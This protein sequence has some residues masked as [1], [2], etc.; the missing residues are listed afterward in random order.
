MSGGVYHHAGLNSLS[1]ETVQYHEKGGKQ[2]EI[3][4]AERL[5]GLDMLHS[6]IHKD[7]GIENVTI[8]FASKKDI[9]LLN[10]LIITNIIGLCICLIF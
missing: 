7:I 2:H 1:L 9:L 5:S 6:Y 4:S 8:Q 3:M 10:N